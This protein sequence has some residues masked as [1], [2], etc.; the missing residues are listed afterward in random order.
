LNSIAVWTSR[1]F[2]HKVGAI[3]D[4]RELSALDRKRRVSASEA[5]GAGR[6]LHRPLIEQGLAHHQRGQHN[7]ADSCY[8]KALA[9][10]PNDPDALHY[11]GLLRHQEG[12]SAAAA[13][14][15]GKALSL[16]PN[17]A[18]TSNN[19]GVVLEALSRR[20]EAVSAY[21]R[22]IAIRP[23]Y[24]EAWNNRGNAFL[25]LARPSKALESYDRALAA[26]PDYPEA[27]N[28]RGVAL[29]GLRRF[30]EA[31][32]SFDRALKARANYAE[33]LNNRGSA[34][35]A[36]GD[37]GSAL[38]SFDR[39]L[40]LSPNYAEALFNRGNA[41]V[42]LKRYEAAIVSYD[43]ALSV[44]PDYAKAL[45]NR[46]NTLKDQG[47]LEE[48]VASY[49]RALAVK[50]DYADAHSNLLFAQQ[51]MDRY[52]EADLLAE[53]RRYGEAAVGKEIPKAFLNDRKSTRRLRIGYV[54]GDFHS[55]PVGF[56]SA[57]VLEAHNS[58]ALEV[59]CYSN[60]TKIDHMTERFREAADHWR[61]IADLSDADASA[62]IAQDRIDIL[63]DLSGHTGRNR[64]PLFARRAAP[65]QASWLGYPGTTG[66]RAID[67]LIMDEYAVLPREE[68]RYTEAIVR[69]PYG[70][71]CYS[72]PDY[73]PP[74]IDPP[75]LHRGSVTFGSF[76]NVSKIGPE[77]IELWASILRATPNSR[78]LFK[79]RSLDDAATRRRLS[80]AFA[81]V[82][83][84][85]HRLQFQR[86]SHHADLMAQYGEVDIA[87]DPFPFSG[88][89]TTCEAL[90]MGVPVVTVPGDRAASRHVLGAFYDLGLSDCV[91]SSATDYLERA[92]A[93]ARDPARL[94]SLRHSL[95]ERMAASPLCDGKRFA[96][97]LERAYEIMWGGWC[98]GQNPAPFEVVESHALAGHNL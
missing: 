45:N 50:P 65:V 10:E 86:S 84:S 28:N 7:L 37:A 51:Y 94:T 82:G 59:F 73:A 19:L 18:A 6:S 56:F 70:R 25:G 85:L 81:A 74:P 16:R 53:A 87:L 48:G 3:Q 60:H 4:M 40:A 68:S 43:R 67:Y 83:I 92:K 97:T 46:G 24:A 26:K 12:R 36:L 61:T 75:S 96:A 69:L 80:G 2:G 42:E 58:V 35:L 15:I 72:P 54:S 27:H 63:V 32:A 38:E 62:L 1:A 14:L 57:R 78:L 39:A 79:W 91:A 9:I 21:D 8:Q 13:D 77:V 11:L 23:D 98:R 52:S 17:D 95:R 89:L 90:W 5:V 41:L 47:R 44:R 30:M 66:L 22:A 31:V 29:H 93:L 76:N 49:Q 20:E 33:A 55:H 88:G 64:L 34:L 71:F